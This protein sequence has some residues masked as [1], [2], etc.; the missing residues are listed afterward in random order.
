MNFD[1]R[2]FAV[3]AAVVVALLAM[4]SDQGVRAPISEST[5]SR[6]ELAAL[7]PAAAVIMR[8]PARPR[9]LA[10]ALL[11]KY[12]APDEIVAS[13]LSWNGR[14]P[15]KKIVA[16]RDPVSFRRSDYLLQTV[17]YGKVPLDR[18][19]ELSAFGHGASYDPLTQELSARTEREQ[20]NILA[21]NLADEVIGGRRNA[22]NA[23][24]FYDATLN[25]ARNGKSSPYMT[26]LLF[27]PP[28]NLV[29]A[30]PKIKGEDGL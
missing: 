20:T 11:E 12:G 23:R 5:R 27:P 17:A 13:Q 10:G 24:G 29:P 30:H 26:R 18:W 16:F 6:E 7:Q 9:A 25:L 19:R 28:M 15:W 1:L 22:A 3:A 4:A 21:L 14:R 2:H 8:W